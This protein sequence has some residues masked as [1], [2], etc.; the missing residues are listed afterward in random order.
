MVTKTVDSIVREALDEEGLSIHYYA[1]F[2]L[3]ILT[4]L[5]RLA[6]HHKMGAKQQTLTINGYNRVKLP[7][8]FTYLLDLSIKQGERLLPARRD[9]SLNKLY[10]FDDQGNKIPFPEADNAD[11]ENFVIVNYIDDFYYDYNRYGFGGFFGLSAP[12]DRS[13]NVDLTNGEIVFS[14]QFNRDTIV[15]TYAVDPVSCSSCNLVTSEYVDVLKSYGIKKHRERSKFYNQ[16][17]KQVAERDY[18]NRKRQMRALIYPVSRATLVHAFR[19]GY[20]A[21]PKS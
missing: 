10:N 20:H 13:F 5:Q 17:E 8:D 4:E 2:L 3:D 19:R 7:E 12:Q 14:N 9:R 11:E 15:I 6:I 18:L 21:A 16:Y 1:D